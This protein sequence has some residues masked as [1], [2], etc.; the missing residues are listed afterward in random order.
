MQ[1]LI[2]ALA[3]AALTVATVGQGSARADGAWLDSPQPPANWNQERMA[4]PAPPRTFDPDANPR[5]LDLGVRMPET[6]EDEALVQAG[7]VLA[8]AY[9][10]GW[11]TKVILGLS[12]FDGMCRYWGYNYFVFQNG[13]FAG[14]LAPQPMDSRTDGAADDMML[15]GRERIRVTYR[16][17]TASDPLC[18]PSGRSAVMFSIT[19][20]TGAPLVRPENVTTEALAP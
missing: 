9:E 2:V 18:C 4:I 14:T 5:C 3:L 8:G 1:R 6:D 15:L 13:L 7:W 17:Y 16:R 11:G 20:E 12:G 19:N 10:A